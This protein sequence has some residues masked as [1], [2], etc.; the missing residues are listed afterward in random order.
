MYAQLLEE[1]SALLL[2][3]EAT[4]AVAESCTGGLLGHWLTNVP[5]SSGYF[6]GGLICYSVE[7]KRDVLG[8]RA[9]TLQR[10]GAVSAETAEEMA[11]RARAIFAATYA[12]AI[13]GIAGPAPGDAG[14]PVG[15]VHIGLATATGQVHETHQWQGNRLEN[16]E[17][18]A[19]AALSLLL[20]RLQEVA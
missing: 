12:L 8:M 5:G 3:Q 10:Y 19:R 17:S 9:E 20:R 13:T 4:V 14:E 11:A 1:V 6:L 16:K 18:A 2:A 15:L 7:S